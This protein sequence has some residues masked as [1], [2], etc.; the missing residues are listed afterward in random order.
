MVGVR[1]GGGG[2]GGILTTAAMVGGE[3]GSAYLMRYFDQ[4][5]SW[6]GRWGG[7]QILAT[8]G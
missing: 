1:G 2:G 5:G 4:S 8:A 3:G 7:C 6:W